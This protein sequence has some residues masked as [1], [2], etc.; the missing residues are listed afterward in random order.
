MENVNVN[1][2]AVKY[3]DIMKARQLKYFYRNKEKVREKRL[4]RTEEE[5][6]K[7]RE[8]DK[9]RRDNMS[10]EKKQKLKEYMRNYNKNIYQNHVVYVKT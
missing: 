6:Q 2:I 7:Q 10:P 5:K 9:I 1:I 3:S 4:N 8:K